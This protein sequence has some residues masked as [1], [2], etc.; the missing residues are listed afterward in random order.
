MA[1]DAP[2]ADPRLVA[3]HFGTP[4]GYPS[5]PPYHPQARPPEGLFPD[6]GGEPNAAYDGVRE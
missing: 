3:A 6:A 2:G 5:T 1:P 4:A